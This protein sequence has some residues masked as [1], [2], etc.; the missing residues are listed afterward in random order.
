MHEV[1]VAQH[2]LELAQEAAGGQRILALELRL[3]RRCC[4]AAEALRF[5]F[6]LVCQDTLA[7]GARLDIEDSPGPELELLSLEV[8]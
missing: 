3:G 2:L 1:S 4:V 5:C 7:Q 8:E 6:E